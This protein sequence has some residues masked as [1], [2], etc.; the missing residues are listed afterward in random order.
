MNKHIKCG[1]ATLIFTP[2]WFYKQTPALNIQS[3]GLWMFVFL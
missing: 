3:D 2:F 1:I